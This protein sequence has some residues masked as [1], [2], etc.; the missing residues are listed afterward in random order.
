MTTVTFYLI[1]AYTPTFG[2]AMLHLRPDGQSD[3]DLVRRR[4]QFF[5]AAGDGRALRPNRAKAAADFVTVLALLTAYPAM[6]WLTAAP[7]FAG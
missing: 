6:L 4:F 3:R 1:T 7:S 5:L 2:S